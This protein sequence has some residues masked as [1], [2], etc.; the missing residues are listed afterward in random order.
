MAFCLGFGRESNNGRSFISDF[1]T[2]NTTLCRGQHVDLGLRVDRAWFKAFKAF[3][4]LRFSERSLVWRHNELLFCWV[5][6][7]STL[8]HGLLTMETTGQ[9]VFTRLI[10]REVFVVKFIV[11]HCSTVRPAYNGTS[12]VRRFFTVAGIFRFLYVLKSE[13]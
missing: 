11:N 1:F 5:V 2:S 6:S 13:S 4:C 7:V 3:V 10:L 8:S 9:Y 12:S